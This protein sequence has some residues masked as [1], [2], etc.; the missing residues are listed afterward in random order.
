MAFKIGLYIRVST[1]EQALRTEGSLDSQKHRL[2]GYVDI[3]NLQQK[4]W[5]M[6]ID[7]YID[8]GFSAKDTNRPALKKLIK[9][10]QKGRI[11]TVLVTDLSRLSR[12]IRDFCGLLDL[13]KE[14]KSQFL[15]LKEQFDTTTAAGEMMLFNMINLAQ[16]ERRQISERVILNFHSRALR[17]LRNGGVACLGYKVDPTNKSTLVVN[18]EEVPLVEKVF[19]TYI[20]EK[21]A[22]ATAVKLR[23]ENVPY[24]GSLGE[25]WNIST[26]KNILNNY[27]YV[28]KKEVN[29]G[30]KSKNQDELKS[31]EK[32]QIVPASWPAIVDEVTF[33][34]VQKILEDNV[35]G[36][37]LRLKNS[38]ARTFLFSGLAVCGECGRAIVGSTGHGQKN[39]IRYYIHRPLE[40]KPVTCSV[41]R[42][43]AEEI[44]EAL[45]NHLL[46][47][48]NQAG[49]LDGIEKN[50]NESMKAEKSSL[51]IQKDSA[52]KNLVQLDKDIKQLVKLQMQTENLD[53]Q[54]LYSEQLIELQT[55]RKLESQ[56][57]ER[58]S[59][60]L[61]DFID[62]KKFV[63]N[64]QNVL[65]RL[66]MAWDKANPKMRKALLKVI[67]EKLVFQ[68]GQVQ[69]YYRQVAERPD[70]GQTVFDQELSKNVVVDLNS[71]KKSQK[72][73]VRHPPLWPDSGKG[74]SYSGFGD[75]GSLS[76]SGETHNAK[77]FRWYIGLNGCGNR[78]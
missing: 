76:V 18:N 38:K 31:F 3:K 10:L 47:V 9:D 55:Q 65:K 39:E 21:S 64:L 49:Y 62:S 37:R 50:V 30:N 4:D 68:N 42:Y 44:E 75:L 1:E 74:N 48:I 59:S 70:D 24:K 15:S 34:T 58:C 7:E 36:E 67:I 53:L 22:H 51:V 25:M 43:R 29:K 77:D 6:V 8:D 2:K 63:E 26:V 20:E 33:N 32:Y 19:R 45:E 54:K 17:G 60:D 72:I 11:N 23:Q 27:S 40:G 14:T 52:Q 5:G 61:T 71:I 35:L 66:Q 73:G 69:I 13:F 16:F 78:I 12:S 56:S 41:K 46:R 28:G 57:L